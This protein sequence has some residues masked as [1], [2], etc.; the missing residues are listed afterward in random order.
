MKTTTRPETALGPERSLDDAD[1]IGAVLI[2]RLRHTT[3][4]SRRRKPGGGRLVAGLVPVADGPMADDRRRALVE[5]QELM[6]A[7][8]STLGEAAVSQR[9]PWLK[10]LGEPPAD[11]Q[12]RD[13]WMAEVRTVAAF[14]DRYGVEC[15]TPVC[16]DVRTDSQGLDAARA[17]QAVCRTAGISSEATLGAAP[18]TLAG[19][20]LG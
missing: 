15:S 14:R 2:S 8:V 3:S 19:Q 9:A 4:G 13:Q 6:E 1:N 16:A 7:R 20:V 18:P 10:R 11:P 12:L 17:R 5:R